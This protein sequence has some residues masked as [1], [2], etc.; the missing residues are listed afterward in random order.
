[1]RSQNST[2]RQHHRP[3][4][5]APVSASIHPASSYS[6][7]KIGCGAQTSSREKRGRHEK[8]KILQVFVFL[9]SVVVGQPQGELPHP[10]GRQRFV[11]A[12]LKA[13]L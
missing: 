11:G 7:D 6:G 9:P 10:A 5:P 3:S 12:P 4:P 2:A 13:L 1:M 8:T